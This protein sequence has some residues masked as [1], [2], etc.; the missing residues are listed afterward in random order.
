MNRKKFRN[1]D[2]IHK[3]TAQA[4]RQAER[5]TN[6]WKINNPKT[7]SP[8]QVQE[9]GLS[10]QTNKQTREWKNE[11]H[12]CSRRKR[13]FLRTHTLGRVYMCLPYLLSS[14][15]VNDFSCSASCLLSVN[16]KVYGSTVHSNCL[17]VFSCK[18]KICDRAR[19]PLGLVY[20]YRW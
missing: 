14:C 12:T 1:N 5:E 4:E 15:S 10:K 18:V 3:I 13:K 8:F 17:S 19:S 6:I 16:T 7:W 9:Q 2:K 11:L 20:I